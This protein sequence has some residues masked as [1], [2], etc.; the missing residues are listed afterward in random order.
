MGLQHSPRIV[1]DGLVLC[2]D[3][4]D[5]NSYPGSGNTW[6][7]LSGQGNNGTLTNMSATPFD[8]GNG[9][10]LVFD[11][12]NDYVVST[13][14]D[15]V[16]IF[17]NSITMEAFIKTPVIQSNTHF[18]NIL[19][20]RITYTYPN[21][22]YGLWMNNET[23]PDGT[24]YGI[25]HTDESSALVYFNELINTNKWFHLVAT[26]DGL[27]F[28]SYQNSNFNNSVSLTGN[29]VPVNNELL[30]GVARSNNINYSYSFEGNIA[31]V[32][33][34]NRALTPQEVL[35]NYNATKTRFGL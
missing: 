10:S 11:G 6:T 7:D 26:Y 29:I 28:K 12:V 16:K 9:G 3:A 35:Q 24:S 21:G 8:S 13:N 34:Y 19:S 2:L 27:S 18:P 14:D 31:V 4:A 17:N 5:K 23:R 25:L 1:T 22:G 15:S 20:K 30:I 33:L 32:R